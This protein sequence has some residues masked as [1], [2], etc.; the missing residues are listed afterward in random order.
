MK[1]LILT[2]CLLAFSLEVV[3]ALNQS[4]VRHLVN[5]VAILRDM[6]DSSFSLSPPPPFPQ[7]PSFFLE[8]LVIYYFL[9]LLVGI[10]WSDL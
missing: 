8:E 6:V 2:G 5:C 3:A 10:L 9:K 4:L 7:P 1:L